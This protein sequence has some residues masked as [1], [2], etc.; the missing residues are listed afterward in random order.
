M[1][2]R[3]LRRA[4]L[5]SCRSWSGCVDDGHDPADRQSARCNLRNMSPA[6]LVAHGEE[7]EEWGGYFIVNGNEKLIRLLIMPRRHNPI[8]INRPSFAHKGVG[9]TQHC[10][11]I[12]CVRPDQS[13][14]H[15]HVHYLSTGALTLRFTHRKAEY[16]VPLMLVLKALT[17]ASDKDV[18]AAL[19]QNDTD[20][21]FIT[22]RAE[23]L[24]RSFKPYALLTAHQCL[25]FLGQRFRTAFDSP[26][27][28]SDRDVGHWLLRKI[29]L[30]H[31][32]SYVDK[33]RMLLYVG[34]QSHRADRA[35]TWSASST[36]L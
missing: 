32:D 5:V 2:H 31:L 34:D 8:A 30:V 16:L 24:I 18:F 15:N 4:S 9:Y 13:S 17:D 10:V 28:M 6:Q 23:L 20:N 29:V 25:D 1:A 19:V 26:D 35:A 14:L 33:Y 36:R 21:T 12:R 3:T 7:A 22:D 27:D 11:S